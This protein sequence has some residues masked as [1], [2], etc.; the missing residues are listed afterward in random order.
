MRILHTSD[1]HLGRTLEG[2]SRLEE[3]REFVDD[4]CDL[5]AAE[6]IHLIVIAGDIFDVYNP[7]AEAENLFF[8]ALERLSS[9]GKR[10]VVA[11]AGNH[12]SPERLR[13]ANP[14]ALTHGISLI[15]YPLEELPTGRGKGGAAR[16]ASG[17]GW[18]ELEIPGCEEHAVVGCLAYP[19]EARLNEVLSRVLEDNLLQQ[20]YTERIRAILQGLA[21]RFRPDT[22]NLV[23]S[24]LYMAGGKEAESER[25]IQLGGALAVEARA[26]PSNAHYVALGHLHR[27]QGVEGAPV[28]CRYAGSPLAY[29][30]SET[31]QPKEVVIVEARPGSRA[32]ITRVPLCCGR[33]LKTW[34]ACSLEEFWTWCGDRENLRCWVDL[35]IRAAEPL[36]PQEVAEI[37]RRHPGVVNIRVLLPEGLGGMPSSGRAALPIREQFRLFAARQLGYEPPGELVDL[38]LELLDM[39]GGSV[40]E[41]RMDL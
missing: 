20:A 14:L 23:V 9:G 3:Q 27:P 39:E 12:D 40:P 16:V 6:G 15:G 26:L 17:P 8:E 18:L 11:I 38:F 34:R 30:F 29:S 1:W 28:P 4:L 33:P 25:P 32:S 24:H 36:T 13:A 31:D 7:P 2:R 37:R 10:A 21:T 41:G 19:S 5:V 22:V 35:E